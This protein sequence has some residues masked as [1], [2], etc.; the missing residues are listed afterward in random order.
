MQVLFLRRPLNWPAIDDT[1]PV[2]DELSFNFKGL[3][4]QFILSSENPKLLSDTGDS[5]NILIVVICVG[6]YQWH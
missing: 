1:D 5:W 2:R 6:T 4:I 3:N